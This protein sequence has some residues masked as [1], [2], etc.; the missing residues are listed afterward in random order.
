MAGSIPLVS[1]LIPTFNAG[2]FVTTTIRSALRQ[3]LEDFEILVLDDGS[4][5]DTVE[6]VRAIRDS[7]LRLTQHEHSGAPFVLNAGLALAR[8]QFIALL[9]HDDLWLPSKLARH[10]AFFETHPSAAVTFSWCSLIDE[11]DRPIAVHPSR[12]RGSI[13]FRH[14]LED[15]VVG[16]SSTLVMRRATVERAGASTSRCPAVTT[17]I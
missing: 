2:R 10:V 17:S 9:D 8:G 5:D 15:Y 6:R 7:R 3:T 13:G 4:T 1:V 14:L 16:S 11:H 12:W